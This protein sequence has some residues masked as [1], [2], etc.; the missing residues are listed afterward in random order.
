MVGGAIL[1]PMFF[2]LMALAAL[3]SSITILETVVASIE[4]YSGM[5][6]RMI[7][8][9]STIFLFVLGLGTVFSFNIL[10]DFHPLA[11]IPAFESKT[12][13]ESLDYIVS[14][15]M[16]P[17]GGVLI[18]LLAGWGLGRNA[19]RGELQVSD[20]PWFEVWLILVRVVVPI[21]I[22]LVF[23]ANLESS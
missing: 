15:F 17:L 19:T 4:D 7:S 23:V 5:S 9:L 16:M 10:E 1:G 11:M 2:I 12:I 22:A 21:A 18:A 6:R 13:F 20:G 14:N 3:T 8:A